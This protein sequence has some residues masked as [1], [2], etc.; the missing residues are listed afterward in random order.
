MDNA[1]VFGWGHLLTIVGM[2][3]TVWIAIAGFRTIE[4]WRREKIEEKKIDISIQALALSYKSKLVFDAIQSAMAYGHEW[5]DMPEKGPQNERSQRGAFYAVLK[6]VENNKEFFQRAW[7]LQVECAAIFGP[8]VET[9]FLNVQRARREIEVAAQMLWET[10]FSNDDPQNKKLW[11]EMRA[12]VWGESY[13]Q[14]F[15]VEDKVGKLL[16]EFRD[17]VETLCRPVVGAQ[18]TKIKNDR[19]I[20]FGGI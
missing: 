4:H 12:A 6:R 20:W 9:V 3:I 18:Y 14:V 19:G 11:E 7:E 5:A 17:G 13:A 10:P 2:V 16:R 15:K 1:W 8:H